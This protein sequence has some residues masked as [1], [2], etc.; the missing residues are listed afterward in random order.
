MW[1]RIYSKESIT[2]T[3]GQNSLAATDSFLCIASNVPGVA[4]LSYCSIVLLSCDKLPKRQGFD[5]NV[6]FTKW[7]HMT[8]W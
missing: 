7:L 3:G 2:Q 8:I 4:F 5:N 6:Y 1:L